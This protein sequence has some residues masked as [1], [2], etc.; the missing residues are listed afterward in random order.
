M[1]D[2]SLWRA[3]LEVARSSPSPHNVQPWRVRLISSGHAE[4]YIDGTRTLPREDLTGCFVLSAM[5]MFLEALDIS[6]TQHGFRFEYRLADDIHV[7]ARRMADPNSQGLT[8]FAVLELSPESARTETSD[9]STLLA[10]TTS[11]LTLKRTPVPEEAVARLTSFALESEHRYTHLTDPGLIEELLDHNITAV[12]QD[13]NHPPYHDEIAS[14]F[15]FSESTAAT[16]RD[17]LDWRCMNLSKVEFWMSARLPRV[18]KVPLA[19]I[20]FRRR[21]RKQ[22]GYVPAIGILSGPFFEPEHTIASGRF[23]LRF[24]LEVTAL[25]LYL[26]PYGNLVT[27]D[28]AAAWT[29]QRT[30]IEKSWLIFKI[31]YSD[32]PPHSLRRTVDQILLRQ[33]EVLS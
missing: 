2:F 15:R 23:L 14:W 26:H 29:T 8:L 9:V 22:L 12:F 24:W 19:R 20:F 3:I 18:L 21:Y 10:R 32:I 7:F 4:L 33:D 25:D 6:A 17:G 28:A 16:H 11:R 31:G 13:M 27:N 30:G 5:G 1:D